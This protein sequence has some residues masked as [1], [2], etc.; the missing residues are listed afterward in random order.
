M[1]TVWSSNE[2]VSTILSICIAYKLAVKSRQMYKIE[3]KTAKINGKSLSHFIE[4]ERFGLLNN[5]II[6][7]YQ[8][9]VQN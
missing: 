4:L 6:S 8:Y 2:M 9:K 3:M 5:D 1:I 7:I